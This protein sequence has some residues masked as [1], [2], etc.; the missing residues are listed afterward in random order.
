MVGVR[1]HYDSRLWRLHTYHTSWPSGAGV[2]VA[3]LQLV[4]TALIAGYFAKVLIGQ[5]DKTNDSASD[6]KKEI[7]NPQELMVQLRELEG[8]DQELSERLE[9]IEQLLSSWSKDEHK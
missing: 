2:V 6:N 3:A 5:R 7:T 8:N 9:R 1:D 4:L